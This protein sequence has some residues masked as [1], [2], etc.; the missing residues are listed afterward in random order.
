MTDA[1]RTVDADVPDSLADADIEAVFWDIGGVILQMDSAG[2]GLR[3]FIETLVAEY[4]TSL[5]PAEALECW[6]DTYHSYHRERNGTEHQPAYKGYRRA[7][8]AILDVD[9]D[10]VEWRELFDRIYY[11]HLRPN[12]DAVETI[13]RLADESI[14]QGVLSDIDDEDGERI[15]RSFGVF[16]HF[17]AYTSSGAV[18]Q[19][20]PDPA[21]FE[22]AL[23]KAGVAPEAAVMVGDEYEADMEGGNRAGLWTVGHCAEDGSAVD[24]HVTDLRTILGICDIDA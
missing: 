1:D 16:E 21:M 18:G 22:T 4:E 8:D 6:G 20:K 7:V 12:P 10:T 11:E 24:C 14:H 3:A 15:L 2:E 9:A 19:L 17:D 23:S 5:A 13:E